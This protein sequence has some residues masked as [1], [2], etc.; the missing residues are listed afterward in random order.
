MKSI[1][2]TNSLPPPTKFLVLRRFTPN[3]NKYNQMPLKPNMTSYKEKQNLE[4]SSKS[5]KNLE[6]ISIP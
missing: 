3:S 6:S 4:R 2:L 1:L 5:A